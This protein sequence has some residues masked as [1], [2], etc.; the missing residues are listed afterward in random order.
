MLKKTITYTDFNDEE[1]TEDFYFALNKAELMEMQ[2]SVD[3]GLTALLDKIVKEKDNAKLVG[4]FKKMVLDSY[5]EKS[6]DG[7][8]F[9]KDE[10]IKKNFECS[11]AYPEIFMELAEDA[12]K[13]AEFVNGIIPKSL[14]K[15]I[16]AEA[17]ANKD[18]PKLVE[19]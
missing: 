15:E 19:G 16:E 6:L 2:L 9:V 8:T 7:K 4:F 17:A 10:T 5:G 11:A 1:R 3:G 13:A 18:T 14:L 12:A